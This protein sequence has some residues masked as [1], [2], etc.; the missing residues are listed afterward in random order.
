MVRHG[1]LSPNSRLL[2][3]ASRS[4]TPLDGRPGSIMSIGEDLGLIR[5]SIPNFLQLLI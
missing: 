2:P 5:H 3:G 4:A 1:L